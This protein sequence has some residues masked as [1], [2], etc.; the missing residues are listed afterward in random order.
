MCVCVCE[1]ARLFVVCTICMFMLVCACVNVD[2]LVKNTGRMVVYNNKMLYHLDELHPHH[3][4]NLLSHA[5]MRS[6]AENCDFADRRHK[7]AIFLIATAFFFP[8]FLARSFASPSVIFLL[9]IF[10][11]WLFSFCK[12]NRFSF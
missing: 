5:W 4:S 9:L 3:S 1:W 7:N 8:G 11:F 2:K 12:S 10:V 6:I